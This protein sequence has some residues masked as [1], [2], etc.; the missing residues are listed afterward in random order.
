MTTTTTTNPATIVVRRTIAASPE[1]LFDA[2]LDPESAAEIM[3]PGGGTPAEV[4][5]DA[6]VGGAFSILMHGAT[7]P[8]PHHGTYRVI[9]RPRK[10]VFTWIS[11]STGGKE[12][13]VTVE[14]K[15][16]EGGTEVILTHAQLPEAARDGHIKGWT[17]ILGWLEALRGRR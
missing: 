2:W 13:V 6:R 3:R 16:T 8:H 7:K 9:E 5:I 1:E 11:E 15:G 4:T 12:S 14:F 10:L 17:D